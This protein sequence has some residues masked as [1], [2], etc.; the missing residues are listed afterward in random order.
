[1]MTSDEFQKYK[2]AEK[3]HLRKLKEL[4]KAVRHLEREK[5][6]RSAF[7]DVSSA[8]EETLERQKEL[9]D[10]LAMETA[11][12]EARLDM[13]LEGS[14]NPVDDTRTAGLEADLRRERARA[15]VRQLEK[16]MSEGPPDEASSEQEE[17]DSDSSKTSA[18]SNPTTGRDD[19]PEK[20]I[21]RM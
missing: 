15:L 11:M 6:I 3:T 4:K 8:P 1:M 17:P 13:A 12:H 2:E 19:R 18:A 5:S 14:E 7:E 16:E 21:G 9:V 10:R 20:T